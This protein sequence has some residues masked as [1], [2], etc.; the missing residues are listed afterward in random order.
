MANGGRD[1]EK[2]TAKKAFALIVPPFSLKS[3]S[4]KK[5]EKKFEFTAVTTNRK[6]LRRGNYTLALFQQQKN[7]LMLFK[8][9]SKV[10]RHGTVE[11]VLHFLKNCQNEGNSAD[12]F[13]NLAKYKNCKCS[14]YGSFDV[15]VMIELEL[16]HEMTLSYWVE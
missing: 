6:H 16:T 12:E 5:E 2:T 3:K 13:Q 14:I 8:V 7:K 15:N 11:A 4:I 10:D 1:R 9:F